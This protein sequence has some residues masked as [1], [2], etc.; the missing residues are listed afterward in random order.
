MSITSVASP[1]AGR[2]GVWLVHNGTPVV[3][4]V[5]GLNDGNLIVLVVDLT[6]LTAPSPTLPALFQHSIPIGTWSEITIDPALG[7]TERLSLVESTDPA[8]QALIEFERARAVRAMQAQGFPWQA[9]IGAIPGPSGRYE[10]ITATTTINGREITPGDLPVFCLRGGVLNETSVVLFG[11]DDRTGRIAASRATH[12]PA[13]TETPMADPIPAK[14]RLGALTTRLGAHHKDRIAL[15]LVD[16]A[17]DEQIV[18][19]C[20]KAD[21]ADAKTKLDA[22]TTEN[23]ALKTKC[24][25]L[26]QKLA[27]LT[28]GSGTPPPADPT[29]SKTQQSAAPTTLHAAMLSLTAGGCKLKGIALHREAIAKYPHLD[30]NAPKK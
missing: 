30:P 3:T 5:D 1:V 6:T 19:D 15:A 18:E 16:G 9:S 20:G 4:C 12:Q 25:E 8:T 26:E 21:S 11:A 7:V 29:A 14:Q 27:A 24:A 23:A 17:S 10:P 22:L 13:I 28:P 2:D